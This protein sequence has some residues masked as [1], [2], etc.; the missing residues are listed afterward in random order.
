M[1]FLPKPTDLGFSSDKAMAS[2]LFLDKGEER[3][4]T[5]EEYY[6]VCKEKYPVRYFL[7]E[8]R[9]W[10]SEWPR[11]SDVFYWI[12]THTKDR[13]HILNLKEAEPE[14]KEGYKWGWLD[15]NEVLLISS[16][17][18]L[19][20]FVEQEGKN[21]GFGDLTALIKEAEES[22]ALHDQLDALR[23][24]QKDYEEIMLLYNWWVKDR[25][26]EYKVF[27][28][29]LEEAYKKYKETRDD[30]DRD[31]WFDAEGAKAK[32]EEEMLIRLVK[33]RLSLWT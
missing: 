8:A 13:Y 27:E 22:E 1:R 16:F 9:K 21:P 33:I 17:L 23:A 31:V 3:K 20:M 10:L 19:R 30:K 25:F 4:D 28:D 15:R 5:W 12:R 26:E 32:R 11:V 24:Q 18:V 14:N 29:K 7:N 2:E 6:R